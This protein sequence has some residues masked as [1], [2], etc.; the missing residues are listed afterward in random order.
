MNLTTILLLI[1]GFYL[2]VGIG[3][4][5]RAMRISPLTRRLPKSTVIIGFIM[6][7]IFWIP[8]QIAVRKERKDRE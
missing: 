2:I 3:L 7:D 4:G 6:Y 8:M 1:I 5:I